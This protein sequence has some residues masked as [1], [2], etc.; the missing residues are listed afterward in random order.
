[1]LLV[2]TKQGSNVVLEFG[3][4]SFSFRLDA[5]AVADVESE[6]DGVCCCLRLRVPFFTFLTFLGVDACDCDRNC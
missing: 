6:G 1:M 5:K 3:S 2:N 4:L